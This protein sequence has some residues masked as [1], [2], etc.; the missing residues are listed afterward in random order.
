MSGFMFADQVSLLAIMEPRFLGIL[1]PPFERGGRHPG[2]LRMSR[3][4]AV[5]NLDSSTAGAEPGRPIRVSGQ[6]QA[7]GVVAQ[8]IYRSRSG[9]TAPR[10][11]LFPLVQVEVAGD[12]GSGP[13]VDQIVQILVGRRAAPSRSHQW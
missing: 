5:G 8:P 10:E 7:L 6:D 13:L 4:R 3:F 12:Q 2:G 11:D 9:Y 1:E